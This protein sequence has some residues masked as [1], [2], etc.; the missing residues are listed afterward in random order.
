M[1]LGEI[2]TE[3]S[4][5]WTVFFVISKEP[6]YNQIHEEMRFACVAPGLL[7]TIRHLFLE[8]LKENDLYIT[9]WMSY[10]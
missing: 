9:A 4:P 5:P 10:W 1:F 8:W 3:I 2:S 6:K 7:R